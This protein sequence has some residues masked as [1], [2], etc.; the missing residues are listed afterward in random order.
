MA[1][2]P[3]LA[4]DFLARR[5]GT[6]CVHEARKVGNLTSYIAKPKH[7]PV[8]SV[9]Q[10]RRVAGLFSLFYRGAN[11]RRRRHSDEAE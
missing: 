5:P 6:L 9:R 10:S 7:V 1:R 3:P 8:P 4:G 2:G 11:W